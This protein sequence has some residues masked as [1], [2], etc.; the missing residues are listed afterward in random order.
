MSISQE[1]KKYM[2]R[3]LELAAKGL[4]YTAPN[5]MVGCV[6]THKDRIIGEG[7]HREFGGPHA[8]VIAI[9]NVRDHSKLRESVLYVNL[10][11]CSHF[12]KTPPC[13]DLISK[14][15]IPV[16]VAGTMDP[17]PVVSGKGFQLMKEKGIQVISDILKDDCVH[18]NRRF[19]TFHV[20]KRPYIILKWAQ[21]RDKYIDVNRENHENDRINWITDEACRRLV[22]KWRAEEQAILVGSKTV[23]MDNPRLTTRNWPGKSPLRLVIDREGKLTDNL[24][25]LDGSAGTVIF[26]CQP[27]QDRI[28]LTY[29]KLEK[30]KNIIQNILEYLYYKNIQSLIVEGGRILINEFLNQNTWDEARIFTGKKIFNQGVPAPV[31]NFE[32]VLKN[33]FSGNILE[34]YKNPDSYFCNHKDFLQLS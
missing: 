30:G 11:P 33:D 13:A 31:I 28:N 26:T 24:N 18:L 8:E 19:F 17:N 12:G 14:K 20:K 23:M 34:I 1:H 25:I 4:G 3:C 6:I 2:M 22:H 32:P 16:V 15:G 27:R 7:Y 10:E 5:P 9:E 29:I 21:T